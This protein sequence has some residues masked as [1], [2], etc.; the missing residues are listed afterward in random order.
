MRGTLSGPEGVCA[1]GKGEVKWE[2]LGGARRLMRLG[3]GDDVVV[4]ERIDRAFRGVRGR[5]PRA[6]GG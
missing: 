4:R 3:C 5:Q 1:V 6:T 2:V